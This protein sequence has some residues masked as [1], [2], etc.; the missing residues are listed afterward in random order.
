MCD[1]H[2]LRCSPG[3]RQ[4]FRG[5]T[6]DIAEARGDSTRFFVID[7]W[8]G[9]DQ[10]FCLSRGEGHAGALAVWP[11][12]VIGGFLV[13]R[14]LVVGDGAG[15]FLTPRFERILPSFL[16][17]SAVCRLSVASL[18][19]PV[20]SRYQ[21]ARVQNLKL[22]QGLAHK[23]GSVSDGLAGSRIP[24]IHG[25]L[26]AINCEFNCDSLLALLGRLWLA[27]RGGFRI[28]KVSDLPPFFCVGA[29][30]AWRVRIPM[31]AVSLAVCF[32]IVPVSKVRGW[33]N[34]E[35]LG[36][37]GCITLYAAC[38]CIRSLLV[39]GEKVDE[40]YLYGWPAVFST[41][42]KTVRSIGPVNLFLRALA[43]TVVLVGIIC[44]VL[45]FPGLRLTRSHNICCR[46]L[47]AATTLL[48]P[49]TT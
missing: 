39:C 47:R 24:A 26:W 13:T 46:D 23:R 10:V 38:L 5:R 29:F 44:T 42:F 21:T 7:N 18:L 25:T 31:S 48:N 15:A 41:A 36:W 35:L 37:G 4:S 20:V 27:T 45:E 30:Y 8:V 14:S 17:A 19:C 12:F 11:V 1:A 3:R 9:R 16:L 22:V 34:W 2:G 33:V 28:A 43:T 6:D 40:P 32:A 49:A